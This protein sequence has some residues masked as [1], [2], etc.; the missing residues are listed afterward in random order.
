[1]R[2]EIKRNKVQVNA[3]IDSYLHQQ[4]LKHVESGEFGSISGFFTTAT[5]NML[6]ILR[7]E[8]EHDLRKKEYEDE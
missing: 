7:E 2:K 8:Q 1:M 5:A 3:N 4:I 6:A